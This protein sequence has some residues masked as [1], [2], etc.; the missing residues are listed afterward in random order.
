[1]I[2]RQTFLLGGAGAALAGCAAG[3]LSPSNL[4][5]PAA[6]GPS[7]KRQAPG[8]Q[9]LGSLLLVPYDYVPAEFAACDGQLMPIDPN[10]ALFSLIYTKFG[11]DGRTNFA[12]PNMRGR[13]PIAGLS[14][15]IATAGR[16]P[17]RK[18]RSPGATAPL[19]GQLLLV[20]YLAKFLPPQGWAVCDGRTMMIRDY[21]ELYVVM[22]NK[23]GGNGQT[24]FALP[25]L[26]KHAPVQG[27][28][29]LIALRGRFPDRA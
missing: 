25:D 16:F 6:L 3:A 14:Y 10:V 5:L 2:K 22:G 4:H 13:E 9:L 27:L 28:T 26:R 21:P 23:F 12:L 11:G 24:T 20:P 17:G 18:R 1:M 7:A 8:D 15:V 29:Y 19:V